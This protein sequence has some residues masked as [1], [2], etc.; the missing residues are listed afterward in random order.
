MMSSIDSESD[1][2]SSIS[3]NNIAEFDP[4]N[5]FLKKEFF[6]YKTIDNFFKKCDKSDLKNIVSIINGTSKI[7]L[8]VLDW[9]TTKYSRKK[10]DFKVKSGDHIID[11]YI[12]YKAQLKTYKKKY[13]D[14][15]RRKKKFYYT[16]SINKTIYTTLG[17]LNFFKWILTN[18]IIEYV[19]KNIEKINKAMNISNKDD[20]N[21]QEKKK[22]IKKIVKPKSIDTMK[23][24]LGIGVGAKIILNLN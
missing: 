17:Q 10:I 3:Q 15:F 19:E 1:N 23:T 5:F 14:P 8:R 4:V 20:K 11:I 13:F 24:F 12:S 16:Y 9:F 18:N 7:S 22:E 6:L 2:S 21:K